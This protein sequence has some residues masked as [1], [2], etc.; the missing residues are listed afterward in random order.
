VKTSNELRIFISSTFRD[1]QEEREHLVKKIFPEI[2]ALCR[3]RGITF[4]E[5]DLRWG[6]TDEHVALGQVI[7]ACLDEVDKCRPYFIGITGDRYG[8]IPTYTDIQKDPTLLQQHPWIEDAVLDEMSITEMEAHY[9]VLNTTVASNAPPLSI[10]STPRD[11]ARFYFRRQRTAIDSDD[12][13]N[14][15]L[16]RL[17]AYQQRIRDARA[18]V[19]EYSDAAQL[20]DLIRN[21][22]I[23]V[24]NDDF[25]DAKPPTPLEQERARH[26][27]FSLSRRRAYIANPFYLKRLN[28]HAAST[29]PPLVVYAES[30]S[31]KS[32]LFAFWAEGYRR[33]HPDVHVIEH[34][35]GIGA[36]ATDHIGIIQHFCMEIKERFGREE[37]IPTEPAKLETALGQWLGYADYALQQSGERMVAI[38]DGLNQLQGSALRLQWIPD[39]ISPNI[40]LILSST[41]EGTLVE[42]EKRGWNRLGMQALTEAERE[43]LVVRYLA[44]YRKS[45]NAE[46]IRR[47]ASDYKCG[48]PLFLKTL[49]EE[50][51]LVGRH[52]VLDERIA[53]Y[54]EATGTEDLFQRVLERLEGDYTMGAVGEMMTLLWCSRSGLDERELSEV[55]GIARLKIATMIAG[56]DYHLVKK[57]G[58]LT[59]FHDYLRRAVEKRYLADERKQRTTHLRI[60]DYF[61][62][63][64]TSSIASGTEV[65]VRMARELAY[66]LYAAGAQDRLGECL[67][68]MPVFL[69][70]YTGETLYEV[71]SYWSSMAAGTDVAEMYRRGL[72]NWVMEDVEERSRRI[73]QVSNL[74]ERLGHWSTTIDLARERLAAAIEHG[75]KSEEAASHRNIGWL[76][77]LR[78]DHDEALAEL[79][80]SLI[81]FTELGDRSGMSFAIG[82]MGAVHYSRGEYDGALDCF[83]RHL[84]IAE[85][86]GDSRGVAEAIGNMGVGYSSRGEF[87]RAMEC[88]ERSLSIAEELGDRN[89]VSLANGNMGIVYDIRGEYDRALGC[90][91]RQLSIAE[92]MGD[93]S[94]I[95]LGN[96]N[97]GILYSSRGEY[98]RALGC[99]ERQLTIAEELGDRS[100][101]VQAIGNMGIVYH[102]RG[103][104]DRA[105]ECYERQLS[106]CEE[107]GDRTGA[108]LAIGN[109]GSV[110]QD[111]GAY[112]SALDCYHRAAEEHRAG[113]FLKG[114][115]H[116]LLGIAQVLVELVREG[117]GLPECLPTYVSGANAGTWRAMSL[118]HARECVEECISI[119]DDMSK[120]D[121]QFDGRVLL[122]RIEEAEGHRDVALQRLTSMLD[123]AAGDEHRAELHYQ[124]WKLSQSDHA[125]QALALYEALHVRTSNHL[126]RRR[127]A[128]LTDDGGGMG[129]DSAG[130]R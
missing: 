110:H 115:T 104:Y 121:T 79:K 19:Q 35:V 130:T 106:V 103:E 128:E 41:V 27:A 59:F 67:S 83:E 105:L 20:G 58:L 109:M 76:L 36:T 16:R 33:K 102:G 2:R 50:L 127:I 77:N 66:Q 17:R 23:A 11:R 25:A 64:V 38:L 4:T 72:S 94:A 49:L 108:F 124:L 9:A 68:T 111:L 24:I 52:E 122:A 13:T 48:H 15:E 116:W 70:L 92:E 87:D 73:G 74:L 5:V 95:A 60:A 31:G 96:G 54:L 69:A 40:R 44:E 71:L 62:S 99:Y 30:G 18:N 57:V 55:S 32:S 88:F 45:L 82:N 14:D 47:I 1:L 63:G 85:E 51:R 100:R 10:P 118:Q 86:L 6:L 61:Y 129:N 90:Y 123:V 119:S 84:N 125:S 12:R 22:L 75:L 113:N 3:E 42:L 80:Q 126:Y 107:L 98:D 117:G 53:A 120:S 28:E 91:E 114:L 29:D 21:D 56:L 112:D 34:Y 93:R 46:Q 97:M 81:L 37:E 7:R 101:A 39:V 43:A 65:S 26:E 89:G 78:G 8:Y